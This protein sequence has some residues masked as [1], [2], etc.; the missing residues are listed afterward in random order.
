[1]SETLKPWLFA[2][3]TSQSSSALLSNFDLLDMPYLPGNR[4]QIL[5]FLTFPSS[6]CSC[7]SSGCSVWALIGDRTHCL[8]ARFASCSVIHFH[9]THPVSLTSLKGALLTLTHVSVRVARVSVHGGASQPYRNGQYSLVLDVKGFRVVSSVHEPVWYAGVKLVTSRN[10][11]PEGQENE[12]HE[13][14]RW[15]KKWIRWKCMVRKG[16]ARAAEAQSG[17]SGASRDSRVA[18]SSTKTDR[19]GG[20]FESASTT[21]TT[22]AGGGEFCKYDSR[23]NT[24]RCT[25]DWVRSGC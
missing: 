11:V 2:H 12:Y 20:E 1:M 18:D 25:V 9:R 15:M 21:T 16:E 4:V 23:R 19:V 13:M 17:P 5:R 7:S 6:S 22:A 3:C 8:A 14:I 24:T 10:A